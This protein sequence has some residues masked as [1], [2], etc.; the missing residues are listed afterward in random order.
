MFTEVRLTYEVKTKKFS[1][2]Y[3]YENQTSDDVSVFDN[4]DAWFE[5]E[6]AKLENEPN[7]RAVEPLPRHAKN[8]LARMLKGRLRGRK[9]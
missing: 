9:S 1:A 3:K 8:C 7:P 6:R 4:A 5:E 2:D